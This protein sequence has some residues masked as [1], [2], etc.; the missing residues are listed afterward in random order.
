MHH[1]P[2]WWR[3]MWPSTIAGRLTLVI[4]SILIVAMWASAAAYVRDRAQTTF[5]L[6]SVSVADRVGVIVPLLEQTPLAARDN[7]LRTQQPHI[8]DWCHRGPAP[9]HTT[10]MA[11]EPASCRRGAGDPARSW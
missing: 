11:L 5:Q 3:R 2:G 4:V 6:F 9:A 10:G 8:V 1:R 7:L